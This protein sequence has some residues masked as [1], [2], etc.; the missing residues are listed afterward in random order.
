MDVLLP[1]IKFP[2]PILPPGGNFVFS[3]G[4]AENKRY[5]L[6]VN[7]RERIVERVFRWSYLRR[8]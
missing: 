4:E 5:V 2:I 6:R 7:D 3:A 8:I 1:A